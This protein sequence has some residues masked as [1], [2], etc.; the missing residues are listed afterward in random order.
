MA[1]KKTP[2]RKKPAKKTSAEE[3]RSRLL[4]ML[5][6]AMDQV[7]EEGLL[8]LLRQANVLIRNQKVEE[9]NRELEE[10]AARS[11]RGEAPSVRALSTAVTIDDDGTRAAVFVTFGEAR[12]VLDRDEVKQLVR[13]CYSTETRSEAL[14]RL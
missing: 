8:F 6:E 13:A 2:A 9:T 4:R 12:K 3:Q 1:K 5:A 7:N 11:P 14:T 10:L